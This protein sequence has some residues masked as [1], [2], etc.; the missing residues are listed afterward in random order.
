METNAP[1]NNTSVFS[2]SKKDHTPYVEQIVTA[3][4]LLKSVKQIKQPVIHPVADFIIY[5]AFLLLDVKDWLFKFEEAQRKSLNCFHDQDTHWKAIAFGLSTPE[6]L[7]LVMERLPNLDREKY[8]PVPN[9]AR[10][11]KKTAPE[12]N[13][14]PKPKPTPYR[15]KT[16]LE[17]VTNHAPSINYTKVFI[18]MSRHTKN[19]FSARGRKVYPYGQEYVTRKLDLSIRTVERIFS[20]L[21]FHHIISKRTNENYDRKKCATWFVCSSRKQSVYFWDPKC[22]RPKKGSPRSLRKRHRRAVHT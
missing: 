14:N 8:F 16:L 12:I 4:S 20:W 18:F 17:Y 6:V 2:P 10:I 7:A 19:R 9:M 5:T 22:K 3:T 21:N 13:T 11:P 15:E 1:Q